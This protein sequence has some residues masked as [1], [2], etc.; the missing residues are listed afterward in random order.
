MKRKNSFEESSS[1]KRK[2]EQ[3]VNLIQYDF[4]EN[5]NPNIIGNTVIVAFDE[6]RNPY[7]LVLDIFFINELN[8][9]H[10]IDKYGNKIHIKNFKT[11]NAFNLHQPINGLQVYTGEDIDYLNV[12]IN[13]NLSDLIKSILYV[14]ELFEFKLDS[15]K[16]DKELVAYNY[17][18]KNGILLF[19][20]DAQIEKYFMM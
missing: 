13:A 10:F 6:S 9:S 3:K 18:H 11:D 5:K 4:I 15:E 17:N 1:S 7:R 20:V 12:N 8:R 14:S 2:M 19:Q 16:M